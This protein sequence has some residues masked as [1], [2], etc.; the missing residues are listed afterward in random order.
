[1]RT[2]LLTVFFLA[3]SLVLPEVRAQQTEALRKQFLETKA[4]AELGD[5]NILS[6]HQLRM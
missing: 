5:A 4:K 3:G 2:F 1:M 6:V